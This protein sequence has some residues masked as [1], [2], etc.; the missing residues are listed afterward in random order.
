MG[1]GSIPWYST[2]EKGSAYLAATLRTYHV[3]CILCSNVISPDPMGVGAQ[4][5]ESGQKSS[6]DLGDFPYGV[7][8][9]Q[10]ASVYHQ[11][12][13]SPR[14]GVLPCRSSS[15]EIL[16]V[17]GRAVL[18]CR[19]TRSGCVSSEL[20]DQWCGH[21]FV[22]RQRAAGLARLREAQTRLRNTSTSL[23]P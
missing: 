20:P 4:G 10:S 16:T 13:R 11:P 15:R 6:G 18:W 22:E 21:L 8:V 14:L 2:Q 9:T 17:R 3:E 7:S 1:I 12:G 5:Y 23:C 19:G